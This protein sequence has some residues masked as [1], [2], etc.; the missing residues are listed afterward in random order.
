MSAGGLNAQPADFVTSLGEEP[1][2]QAQQVAREKR[3]EW[4]GRAASSAAGCAH[5]RS[6]STP[7]T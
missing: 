3:D 5:R 7:Q 2:A 6:A 4:I 1:P